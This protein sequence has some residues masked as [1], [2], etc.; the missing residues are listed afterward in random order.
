VQTP[1]FLVQGRMFMLPY[2]ME[3][4]VISHVHLWQ[5]I[6]PHLQDL[7]A[8][9]SKSMDDGHQ[10][11]GTQQNGSHENPITLNPLMREGGGSPSLRAAIPTITVLQRQEP[12]G[13]L[14][15]MQ[16]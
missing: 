5:N 16:R 1:L 9:R 4:V 10:S 3:L 12:E 8:A 15:L 14:E 11:N 7:L 6:R 13:E 2:A